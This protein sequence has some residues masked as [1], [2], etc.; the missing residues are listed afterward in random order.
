MMQEQI[1]VVEMS[2][3]I[4]GSGSGQEAH[5]P[6]LLLRGRVMSLMKQHW[7]LFQQSGANLG[8]WGAAWAGSEATGWPHQDKPFPAVLRPE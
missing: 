6:S 3:E 4:R 8:P 7:A 1:G 5:T 2:P